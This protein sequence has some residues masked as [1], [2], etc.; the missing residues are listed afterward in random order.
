MFQIEIQYKTEVK[1]HVSINKKLLET[2]YNMLLD[3]STE[4]DAPSNDLFKMA[5]QMPDV[6][7]TDDN[8][9]GNA[10]G[11]ELLQKATAQAITNCNEFRNTEGK[12]IRTKFYFLY[13]KNT[14]PLTKSR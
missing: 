4:L 2:Y 12:I 13:K 5:M 14:K 10:A 6:L 7:Q 11:W 3:S 8:E 9:E 1:P